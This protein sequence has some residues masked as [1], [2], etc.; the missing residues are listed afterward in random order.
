MPKKKGK[1]KGKG[2]KG[3]GKGKSK[4][5]A[6]EEKEIILKKTKDVLKSYLSNCFSTGSCSAA[7]VINAIKQCIEEE[8]PYNKVRVHR[9]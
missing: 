7:L 4:K 9:L 3:K 1:A 6:A 2:K 8:R 5:K